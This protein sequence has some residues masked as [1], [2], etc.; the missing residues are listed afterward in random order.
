MS[1]ARRDRAAERIEWALGLV[2]G[3]VVLGIIG[4]LALQGLSS[5]RALPDLVVSA[6]PAAAPAGAPQ[7][8]FTLVNRGGRAATAVA[9]SLTLRDGARVVGQRHLTVDQVPA[10]SQ[11]TGA[12][13]LP[14][15]APALTP[16]LAVEG[17]LDP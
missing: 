1:T 16:E 9:L 13:L 17:Y 11:V 12:F 3:V 6:G 8:R 2:S 4:Y 7:L 5:A 14:P 10:H 15:D